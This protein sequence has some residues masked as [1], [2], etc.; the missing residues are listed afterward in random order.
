MTGNSSKMYVAKTLA[1]LE[2]LLV[3]E[4]I[5]MGFDKVAPLKRGA[6]FE[7]DYEGMIK[8]N[9]GSRYA[10]RILEPFWEDRV[11]DTDDLYNKIKRMPWQ[12]VL[13][14]DDTFAVN[15][16]T[17]SDAFT[18][19]H[20]A[21][22]RV[23]DAI[24]DRFR[25]RSGNRPSID[26]EAPNL[27]IDVMIQGDVLRVSLDSSGDSL[28]RRGYRPASAKAPLNEILAAAMIE[29]SGWTPEQ[30]LYIPMCGS[31]TLVM[32]AAMR[33]AG[34]PSQWYRTHYGFMHWR[35]FDK[36]RMMKVRKELWDNR[37]PVVPRIY[38]SDIDRTAVKQTLESL[39]KVS[40]QHQVTVKQADFFAL[41]KPAEPGV[42]ILNPPY[43]ERMRPEN[44]EQL[45]RDIGKKLKES[46][47]GSKA[48]IISS[49][50]DAYIQ[51]GF[52]HAAKHTLYNGQL[53]CRYAGFDLYEGSRK[54]KSITE[55]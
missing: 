51:L 5:N 24:V 7:T 13:G 15:A 19:S 20:F 40:W 54:T 49:N 53:E 29:L 11:R 26:T 38:A 1:G 2:P 42:I 16:T 55:E 25:E 18:H 9:M 35:N 6:E 27:R 17:K 12:D 8:A 32:E 44:I 45:Y 22:L 31:G 3:N 43:G 50:Y 23:K 36:D 41:E 4:L 10:I 34:L 33:A 28:H 37:T 39:S 47:V 14:N 30:P 46:Y 52:R 48:W 21:A